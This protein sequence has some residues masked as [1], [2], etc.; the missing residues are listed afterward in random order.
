MRGQSLEIKIDFCFQVLPRRIFLTVGKRELFWDTDYDRRLRPRCVYSNTSWNLAAIPAV[1]LTSMLNRR[2]F[3]CKMMKEYVV[4]L[5]AV[6][7][8]DQCF[9]RAQCLRRHR[10]AIV[11]KGMIA[12]GASIKLFQDVKSELFL[13]LLCRGNMSSKAMPPFHL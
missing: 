13:C 11:P 4:R 3:A 7:G 6:L 10:R 1:R 8:E 2:A 12:I 9:S 5:S